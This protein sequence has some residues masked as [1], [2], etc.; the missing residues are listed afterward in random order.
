M[1]PKGKNSTVALLEVETNIVSLPFWYF[2]YVQLFP[3][4]DTS[5]LLIGEL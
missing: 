2:F 5:F 3:S 4:A 1:D